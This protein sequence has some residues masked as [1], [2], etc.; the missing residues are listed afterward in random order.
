LTHGERSVLKRIKY[1]AGNDAPNS[2]HLNILQQRKPKKYFVPDD[3]LRFLLEAGIDDE[4]REE[5]HASPILRR[6]PIRERSE[7]F[8][9]PPSE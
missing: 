3:L 6:C 7:L 2:G 5:S 9:G 8:Q 1:A 4:C